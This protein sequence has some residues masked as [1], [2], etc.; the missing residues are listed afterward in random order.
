MP[1]AL[2]R[3]LRGALAGAAAAGVWAAQQPLDMKRFGVAYDD[4]ELLGKAV[5][6]GR[7]WP[8]VGTAMH[9]ANG[10]LFG[11]VYAN[12]APRIPGPAWL[13]GPAAGMAEH[14][15]TWPSTAAVAKLHPAGDE[16]PQLWGSRAAFAQA[17]W[18]HLL[19]GAV[20]GGLERALNGP[21]PVAAPV[22]HDDVEAAGIAVAVSLNGHGDPSQI[23]DAEHA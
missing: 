14:L 5:T 6:R 23:S 18:R 21:A 3:T 2:D 10:A 19:F 11:A 1:I 9:L 12:V 8:L 13:R 17:T 15:L 16:F 20:L 4:T 22:V 7:S